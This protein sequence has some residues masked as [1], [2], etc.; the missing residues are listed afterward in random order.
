MRN[1]INLIENHD[2]SDDDFWGQYDEEHP[3]EDEFCREVRS[4]L[5]E[6]GETATDDEINAVADHIREIMSGGTM[7][8]RVMRVPESFIHALQPY[9]ELGSHWS[10][11]GDFDR[12]QLY[13]KRDHPDAPLFEFTALADIG[14]IELEHS[15]AFQIMFQEEHEVFLDRHATISLVSITHEGE[16][17][18][19]RPDLIRARFSA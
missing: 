3:E 9:A 10:L 6:H 5:S 18:N 4:V 14:D 16:N 15:V 19:L 12:S 11:E 17:T 1:W 2:E 13:D 7:I 8:F